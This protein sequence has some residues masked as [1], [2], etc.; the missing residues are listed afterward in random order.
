MIDKA[1]ETLLDALKKAMLAPGEQRL[2]KSGKLDGLFPGKAGLNAAAAAQAIRDNL[3]EVARTETKGKTTIEWVRLTPKGV[4][5]VHHHESPTRAMDELQDALHITL[6]GV[7]VWMAGVRQELQALG[8]RLTDE[9]Q[10]VCHRLEVL[11]QRV[12]E[13]LGKADNQVAPLPNDLMAAV[14]WG[15]AAL[16][17]LD[18]RRAGGA[19]NDCPLPDLFRAV[20]ETRPEL[21][22]Q[23]FHDGLRKLHD[24]GA[25]R[26]LPHAGGQEALPE[27]EYALPEG[28]VMYYSVAR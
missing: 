19:A 9:V 17:Y 25:L 2:F 8:Q 11:S 24:R 13:S 4:E 15:V 5:L 22:V 21:T 27:P 7:P 18:K 6:D 23:E 16:A 26:L 1:T 12:A 14:P 10:N 3:L 28:N 20:R